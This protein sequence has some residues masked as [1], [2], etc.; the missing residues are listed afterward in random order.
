MKVVGL[1]RTFIYFIKHIQLRGDVV[2]KTT[3][4]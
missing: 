4:K 2:P 3:G 1:F